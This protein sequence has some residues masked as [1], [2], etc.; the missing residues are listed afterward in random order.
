MTDW[1][2]SGA[3]CQFL[4]ASYASLA[5]LRIAF[6]QEQVV[7]SLKFEPFLAISSC[8]HFQTSLDMLKNRV[9]SYRNI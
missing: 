4:T 6:R 2:L 7:N 8:I 5:V 3:Q 1:T 9:K